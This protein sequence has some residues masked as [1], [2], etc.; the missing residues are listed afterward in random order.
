M[1]EESKNKKQDTALMGAAGEYYI[2]YR[3][4]AEGYAVGLTTHGTRMIDMV[5]ANPDTCKS[6][7]IQTKTMLN[8]FV[9]SKKYTPYWKWPIG[10]TSKPHK[11]LFYAFIDLRDDIRTQIPDVFIVPSNDLEPLLEQS[12]GWFWCTGINEKNASIYKDNWSVIVDVL[13]K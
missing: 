4:S 11:E 7:A 6:I 12:S 8:A 13:S 1:N 9:K 2:A 3:L 5:V 10:K